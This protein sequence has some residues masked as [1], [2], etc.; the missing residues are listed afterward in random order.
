M[1]LIKIWVWLLIHILKQWYGY[2]AV[3]TKL[4]YGQAYHE[5]GNFTST[6][7]KENKNLFG[8]RQAKVRKNFATGT[9]HGHATFGSLFDSVR[10]YFER[11]RDF[12]IPNSDA[13]GYVEATVKS[14]YAEDPKYRQKWLNIYNNVAVPVVVRYS[15]YFVTLVALAGCV[16]A[17]VLIYRASTSPVKRKINYS[18]K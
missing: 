18:I 17:L 14:N 16:Y 3:P 7:F 8:M 1:V 5:T 10:D 15:H 6:I 12:K 2:S 4:L 9:A 13:S 11:Q